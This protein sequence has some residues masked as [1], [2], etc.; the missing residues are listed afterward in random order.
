M[1]ILVCIL[2]YSLCFSQSTRIIY[3]YTFKIDSLNRQNKMKEI[4][5]LDISKEGSNFYS[6]P[7]YMYDSLKNAQIKRSTSLRLKE[8]NFSNIQDK[9]K[10]KFFIKKS[11]PDYKIFQTD[12]IGEKD[13][14]IKKTNDL[15]WKI[16]PDKKSIK[17]FVTQKATA[18]FGG[19][20]WIAWFTTEI[21]F[22]DGPYC[23]HGLPGLI[24]SVEDTNNDHI[25]NIM[26]IKKDFMTYDEKNNNTII[27][28]EKKFNQLWNEYKKDP[29]ASIK[30]LFLN[31]RVQGSVS[32]NGEEL[33]E[34]DIIRNLE[35]RAK[36]EIKANNNFIELNLYR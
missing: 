28:T 16:L 31:S 21:P 26:G 18:N 36:Q 35:K 27:I 6:Y 2:F 5:F 22:Q 1:K 8:Y 19:R 32:W 30:G 13:Y 4:M 14:V 9:S 29:S 15:S 11:Y 7:K 34:S 20:D 24:L 10:V 25:F 23:F 3:E 17:G 12:Q 33:K